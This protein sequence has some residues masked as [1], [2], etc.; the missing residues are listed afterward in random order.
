MKKNSLN[1]NVMMYNVIYYILHTL[2]LSDFLSNSPV[3]I[4]FSL[5]N[6]TPIPAA[7]PGKFLSNTLFNIKCVINPGAI[8]TQVK[9]TVK[10]IYV[11]QFVF[12]GGKCVL[13][14]SK[15]M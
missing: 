3:G 13:V 5:Y 1:Q 4:V 12:F 6:M 9:S 11:S 2:H 8:Q 14:G 10:V 15:S 7:T